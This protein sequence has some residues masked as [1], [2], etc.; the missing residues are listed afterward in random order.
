MLG[1]ESTLAVPDG[2]GIG[3]TVRRDRLE[4]AKQRWIENYPYGEKVT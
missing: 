2:Y 1:A 4:A 3:V